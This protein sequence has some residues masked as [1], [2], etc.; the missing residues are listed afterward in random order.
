MVLN[1]AGEIFLKYA[2]KCTASATEVSAS[3]DHVCGTLCRRL[4][5][6]TLATDSLS[7]RWKHFCFGVS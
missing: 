4:C 3:L 1:F 2:V 7:D 5:S 6:K